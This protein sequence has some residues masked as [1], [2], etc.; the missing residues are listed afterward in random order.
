MGDQDQITC[1]WRRVNT[2][3]ANNR[4]NRLELGRLFLQLR[5]LYS[6]RSVDV[7]RGSG[8]GTFEAECRKRYFNPRT[9]RDLICDCEANDIRQKG[10]EAQ[11]S[12]EKRRTARQASK[13]RRKQRAQKAW[14]EFSS[15]YRNGDHREETR[16]RALDTAF[17]EFARLLPAGVAHAAYKQAAML[18]HPDKGG[19]NE[20]MARLNVVWE[21]L[22]AFYFSRD[23]VGVS[24]VSDDQNASLD[25]RVQ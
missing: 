14:E 20:I 16:F 1:A 8:H 23:V 2:L 19:S 11:T 5:S 18:L 15:K 17:A 4:R 25:I 21:L 22:S 10:G 9:V 24:V 6:E 13:E 12:A 7:R 3:C